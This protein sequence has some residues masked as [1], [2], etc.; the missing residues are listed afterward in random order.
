MKGQVP[1]LSVD[2]WLSNPKRTMIKLYEYFLTSEY[3]QSIA[4]YGKIASLK[5][6]L[7]HAST[8]DEMSSLIKN[9]LETMYN[10]YFDTS[11]VIVNINETNNTMEY[12]VGV[13]V[14]DNGKT[15]DFYSTV[16]EIGGSIV[17]LDETIANLYKNI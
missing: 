4:H 6:I 2:G 12:Q 15:Y 3:S 14:T 9:Q 16:N 17:N 10:N 5:Y 13:T 7:E 8:A 11:E 1:H